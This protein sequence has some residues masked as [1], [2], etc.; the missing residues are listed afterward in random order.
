MKALFASWTLAVCLIVPTVVVLVT[1]E[2]LYAIPGVDSARLVRIR[3][4]LLV[5]G[6]ILLTLVAIAVLARFHYLRT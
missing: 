1:V 2:L 6:V 3:R 5:L 4:A